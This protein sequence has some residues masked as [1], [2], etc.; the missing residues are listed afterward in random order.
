ML[1]IL[2]ADFRKFFA[3]KLFIVMAV[4]SVVFPLFS[5]G[6]YRLVLRNAQ[7]PISINAET[8]FYGFSVL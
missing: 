8:A 6:L 1:K 4:L 7:I 2:K 5:A 3:G